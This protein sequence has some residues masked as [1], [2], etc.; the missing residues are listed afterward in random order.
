MKLNLVAIEKA[1]Y[2]RLAAEGEITSRDF[3]E[4]GGANPIEAILG[5]GWASNSILLSMERTV[6]IDSS[7]IGWLID[8]PHGKAAGGKLVL[9]SAPLESATFLISSRCVPS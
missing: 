1:G 8:S 3:L 6:F 5:D 7:A 9:H 4:S 2:V